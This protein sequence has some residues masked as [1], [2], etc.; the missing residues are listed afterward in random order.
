M[1]DCATVLVVLVAD[2]TSL[3]SA[4]AVAQAVLER[5]GGGGGTNWFA[6][7]STY[8]FI[9]ATHGVC[10]GRYAGGVRR[11]RPAAGGSTG[12]VDVDAIGVVRPSPARRAMMYCAARRPTAIPLVFAGPSAIAAR[13]SA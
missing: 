8:V 6:L 7:R 2:P 3:I 12:N 4:K 11:H 5:A 13:L 9:E 10:G 1:F